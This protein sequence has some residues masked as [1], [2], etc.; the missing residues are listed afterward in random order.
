MS[1]N[2]SKAVRPRNETERLLI[3]QA[4]AVE[5]LREKRD[6]LGREAVEVAHKLAQ[7][8][9]LLVTYAQ[10]GRIAAAV[11]SADAGVKVVDREEL[12]PALI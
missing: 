6:R 7:A 11:S 4:R 9:E 1:P 5:R 10:G 3:T 2:E 12:Q 8:E